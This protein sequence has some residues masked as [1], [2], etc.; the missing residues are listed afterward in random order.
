VTGGGLVSGRYRLG[1]LLGTGGSASVFAAVD[2]RDD[3]ALALKI[4][5]PHLSND[6]AAR[7]ALLREARAAAG[8]RHPNIVAVLDAGEDPG[9]TAWIALELAPG[10]SLA[11]HVELHG[12]LGSLQTV[13]LAAGV[14]RGLE[15]AHAAG[16]MHRDVSPANIMLSPGADALLTADD[17]RLL[18]FGLADVA[19]RAALAPRAP[20]SAASAPGGALGSVNY[21]SPEQA[22]GAS[23]DE[24]GDIYQLGAVLY[25]ALTGR[26]PFPR[27][28]AAETVEAHLS[29]PPPVPSVVQPRIPRAVDRLVVKAMLKAPGDR[30]PSAAAMLLAVDAL[31][32]G[33][34]QPHAHAQGTAQPHPLEPRTLLLP[35][36]RTS[37]SERRPRL[38]QSAPRPAAPAALPASAPAPPPAADDSS[39]LWKS[40]IALVVVV[41]IVAWIVSSA[42]G[43]PTPQA[44]T[45]PSASVVQTP[46]ASASA[47]AQAPVPPPA[48]VA[49]TVPSVAGGSITDARLAIEAA[50]LVAGEISDENSASAAGTVLRSSPEE[51]SS[52][53]P[54]S[55]VSLVVASGLGTVPEV[56]RL[57]RDAAIAA[58][59]N[60]GFS[61]LMAVRDD[62]AAVTGT[63]LG[64]D[65]LAGTAVLL[66]RPVT[67][68]VAFAP[69]AA[70]PSPVPTPSGTAV[71]GG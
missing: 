21:V 13:A 42:S 18:D 54:G 62:T 53:S 39:W 34:A 50:G 57:G 22:S 28:T 63:I 49:A 70:Q 2:V 33:A 38:P 55:V 47:P 15:A 56:A 29:A 4:L 64:T 20:D 43:G 46:A 45:E 66:G 36:A 25:F 10:V 11:E 48:P 44:A 67:I 58:V 60:A 27:D 71:P 61:V 12:V 51:G 40:G 26:P 69:A 14:L 31:T 52:Q 30:F 7:G 5:H 17:V 16:L 35:A 65:P 24:R 3:S 37:N 68:L 41:A 32:L 19:G 23:V 6:P 8:L 1:E 59:Q 9:G